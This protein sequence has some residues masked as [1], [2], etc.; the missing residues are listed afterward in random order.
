MRERELGLEKILNSGFTLEFEKT[1][2]KKIW[3]T[4]GLVKFHL[5]SPLHLPI[6]NYEC[7]GGIRIIPNLE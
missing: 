3:E 1:E 7:S 2:E 6:V 4:L 5:C